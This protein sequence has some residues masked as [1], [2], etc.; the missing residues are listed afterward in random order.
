MT[1]YS[2]SFP[3]TEEAYEISDYIFGRVI[4]TIDISIGMRQKLKL[5]LSELFMNAYLHGVGNDSSR[6][7][8]V[9]IEF[10]MDKFVTVVKDPGSGLTE[11]QFKNLAEA[12]VDYGSESGRGIKIIR[13]LSDKVE[14]YRDEAGKFCVKC[15]KN[16]DNKPMI[17]DKNR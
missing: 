13:K 12:E 15:S 8:E 14:L 5:L 11:E 4:D 9:S 7:I 3:G 1:K 6:G 10:G 2:F 16:L 17:V